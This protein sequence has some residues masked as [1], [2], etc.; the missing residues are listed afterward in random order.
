MTSF[1]LPSL[2]WRLIGACTADR[3]PPAH[4]CSRARTWVLP[5][6]GVRC[7]RPKC[8]QY[9]TLNTDISAT[10]LPELWSRPYPLRGVFK[11]VGRIVFGTTYAACPIMFR[12]TIAFSRRATSTFHTPGPARWA[13]RF[14]IYACTCRRRA[15]KGYNGNFHA[16]GTCRA[17]AS[18][19]EPLAGAPFRLQPGDARAD[20][21][22][23]EPRA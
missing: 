16:A 14:N 23:R 3:G 22:A 7:G 20:A 13:G 18:E 4:D 15:R 19:Q 17:C 6:P 8:G 11:Y 9:R 12:V 5:K 2:E 21:P 10:Q 1:R